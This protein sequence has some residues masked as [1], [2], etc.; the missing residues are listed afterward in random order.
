MNRLALGLV[1]LGA[2]LAGPVLAQTMASPGAASR[3]VASA[4]SPAGT[5][6]GGRATPANSTMTPMAAAAPVNVNTA[7][8][9]QLDA[10]PR[11]G[12]KRAQAIIAHRPYTVPSDMVTK[13]ALSQGIFNKIKASVTTG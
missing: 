5:I 7:S 11:I 2:L 12:P 8:E 9:A 3:G 4:A 1:A 10:I 13:K 6:T